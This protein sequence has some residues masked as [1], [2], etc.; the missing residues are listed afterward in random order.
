MKNI[1][2]ATKNE[3]KI[4]E[5]R[6]IMNDLPFNIMSMTHANIDVHIE[7][8]GSSF[9]QNALIKA[10]AVSDITDE[11]I[12]ADDSGLEVDYLNGAP[13]IYSSRFAGENATDEQNVEKLLKLMKGVPFEKRTA[14]F[15]CSVVLILPN[16]SR[17]S[18]RGV[19]EGY[20]AFEPHGK[21]GFG[22]DPV[23]YYPSLYSTIAEMPDTEK[24]KISHRAIALNRLKQVLKHE[25]E[26]E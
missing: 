10:K 25:I 7:E 13:G 16:G 8:N 24:N 1:I 18:N 19:C 21:N 12:L 4:K 6:Q 9:E 22:Y 5:I 3:G 23:F 2:V 11:I 26:Q 14:R 15:V 17:I 20:I